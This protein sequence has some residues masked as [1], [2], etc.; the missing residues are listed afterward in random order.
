[1]P[2]KHC[3]SGEEDRIYGM[4]QDLSMDRQKAGVKDS[5]KLRLL[6]TDFVSIRRGLSNNLMRVT[7]AV[8]HYPRY[9]WEQKWSHGSYI[10]MMSL[11][12]HPFR[13]KCCAQ[14]F[15]M[16]MFAKSWSTEKIVCFFFVFWDPPSPFPQGGRL[17]FS[18]HPERGK[19]KVKT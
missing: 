7:I 16:P 8:F 3:T 11:L 13:A 2:W 6:V 9:P 4:A 19:H 5:N 18:E 10:A 17:V 15:T 1:M 14:C 12:V